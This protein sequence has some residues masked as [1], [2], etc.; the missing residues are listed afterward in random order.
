MFD[1]NQWNKEPPSGI[2]PKQH[3]R[4]NKNVVLQSVDEIKMGCISYY[5]MTIAECAKTKLYLLTNCNT[6][7]VKGSTSINESCNSACA[8]KLETDC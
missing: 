7:P 1:P 5:E 6:V 2:S 4:L 3:I 8:S